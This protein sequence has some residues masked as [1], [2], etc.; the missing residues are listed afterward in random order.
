MIG[1]HIST[2]VD[3]NLETRD[4][5]DFTHA[6]GA[7]PASSERDAQVLVAQLSVHVDLTLPAQVG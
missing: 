1:Y 7:H 3:V 4:S 6:C 2:R 5:S